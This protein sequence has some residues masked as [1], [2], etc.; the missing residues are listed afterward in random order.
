[1]TADEII[2]EF[3]TYPHYRQCNLRRGTTKQVAWIEESLAQ[4]GK[5]L[6]INGE[7][8]WR[9]ERVG[10]NRIDSDEMSLRSEEHR[11]WPPVM[12]T[13]MPFGGW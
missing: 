4:L 13:N 1:M 11:M 3:R 2:E 9:V 6:C 8:G 5:Y 7:D 12:P 10:K